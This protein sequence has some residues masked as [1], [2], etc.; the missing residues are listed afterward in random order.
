MTNHLVV[1]VAG[2]PTADNPDGH[3]YLDAGLGDALHEPLPLLAGVYRQGPLAFG[4]ESTPGD[5]GDWHFTHDP[6]GS[7][8]GMSFRSLPATIDGFTERHLFLSTD[9]GSSF[10][11]TPTVQRRDAGGVDILRGLTLSRLESNQATPRRVVTN[12]AEWFDVLAGV[13]GLTL[14]GVD[15][16][17]RDKLWASAITAHQAWE[18]SQDSEQA[19]RP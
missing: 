19:D 16:A 18:E 11:G 2:L 9:P 13:F 8:S 14:G 6:R 1:N 12:R 15:E 17:G 10:A 5:V 4:L 3:W 7:F